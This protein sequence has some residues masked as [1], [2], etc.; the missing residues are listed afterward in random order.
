MPFLVGADLP[1]KSAGERFRALLS[2]H[3]ILQIPGE[4]TGMA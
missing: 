1:K 4:H 3:D 2:R